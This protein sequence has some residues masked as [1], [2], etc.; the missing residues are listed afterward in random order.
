MELSD[1]QNLGEFLNS[2]ENN[3]DHFK[4]TVD[5]LDSQQRRFLGSFKA[6]L[7]PPYF[8]KVKHILGN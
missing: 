8:F 6:H 4:E 3:V 2:V 1:E 5:I 7:A